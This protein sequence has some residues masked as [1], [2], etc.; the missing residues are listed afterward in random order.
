MYTIYARLEFNDRLKKYNTI[1]WEQVG[2]RSFKTKAEAESYYAERLR[3][4][5]T[6]AIRSTRGH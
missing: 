4:D 2:T 1:R 6:L 5:P 3:G